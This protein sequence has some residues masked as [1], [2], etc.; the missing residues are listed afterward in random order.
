M[1]RSR[2]AVLPLFFG[3]LLLSA[4]R[5]SDAVEVGAYRPDPT[6]LPARAAVVAPLRIAEALSIAPIAQLN[7]AED[8]ARAELEALTA[9]NGERRP[10]HPLQVGFARELDRPLHMQVDLGTWSRLIGDRAGD[11]FLGRSR[12]GDFVWGTSAAVE[13]AAALRLELADV[14]LPAGTRLWVYGLGGEPRAF[15]LRHLRSDRTLISPVI[16]GDRIYLEV[17]LPQNRAGESQGFQIRRLH[18]LVRPRAA[19]DPA[20]TE[21]DDCLQNGECFDATDFPGIEIARDSAIQF[22]FTDGGTFVCSATLLNDVNPSTVEP[23]ILTANHCVPTQ[24]VALTMDTAF[25]YRRTACATTSNSFTLGP[26]GADLVVASESTDVALVRSLNSGDV[27]AGAAYAGWT[28][29]RPAD[30]TL[31][32][33]ISHPANDSLLGVYTQMYS[34]HQVDDTPEVECFDVG[35]PL[36][37]FLYTLNTNGTGISG[38][39]SGSAIMLANGQVVGQLFG[40]CGTLPTRDG[41]GTDES[42]IDGALATSFPLL[43][44]YIASTGNLCFRD[45]DTACLLNGKFKVEVEWTTAT[46]T[47]SGTLMA[48]NG[49]RAESD[50][51]AFF[52]FFSATNFEMGVK[53]VDACVAPFNRYWVFVSGL[54]SQQYLVRVTKMSTGEVET[55]FNPLNTL[56]TTEGDTNAFTCP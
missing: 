37:D 23:W 51:S 7:S 31:L 49:E 28:S 41:C 54:T 45:S 10:R 2:M 13:G 9:W 34:S 22:V 42:I 21:A 17:E 53:M 46:G 36:A 29:L 15:D 16:D 3:L 5:P 6:L 8:G 47:G 20:A 55:Y 56:P 38:G 48:F 4:S 44:P 52:W 43:A 19:V 11:G 33:R 27:P 25:F 50:E 18:Q 12:S 39:S 14:D 35:A 32:H 26:F 30:G 40:S 1:T 24:D